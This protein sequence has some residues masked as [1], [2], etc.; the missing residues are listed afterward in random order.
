MSLVSPEWLPNAANKGESDDIAKEVGPG[1]LNAGPSG[2]PQAER[3]LQHQ[4][5]DRN[6]EDA[7]RKRAERSSAG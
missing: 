5:R 1:F 2:R 4:Q 3:E 7:V 6:G